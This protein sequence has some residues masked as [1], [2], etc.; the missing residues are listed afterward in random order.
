MTIGAN[1]IVLIA[2]ISKK[3]DQIGIFLI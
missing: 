3:I 1:G 2:K